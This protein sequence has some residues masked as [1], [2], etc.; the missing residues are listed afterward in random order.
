MSDPTKT[1]RVYCYDGVSRTV[2][3]DWI[4]AD[5]DD[6]AIAKATAAGFGTKCEVWHGN[7]LVAKL[8]DEARSA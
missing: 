5:T 1:Y 3:G 6:E 7:R 2:S 4:E 8:A